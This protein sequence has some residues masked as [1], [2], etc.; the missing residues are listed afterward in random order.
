MKNDLDSVWYY[1]GGYMTLYIFQDPKQHQAW[2]LMWTI[3]FGWWW[4]VSVGSSVETNVPFSE[5]GW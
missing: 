3:D 5:G 4:G 1:N 2:T